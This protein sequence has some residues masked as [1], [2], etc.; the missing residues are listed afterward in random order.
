MSYQEELKGFLKL[1]F[2]EVFNIIDQFEKHV[3][4]NG[5]E[6]FFHRSDSLISDVLIINSIDFNFK[7]GNAN[8]KL[9]V[10]SIDFW[11]LRHLHDATDWKKKSKLK[12][13]MEDLGDKVLNKIYQYKQNL[14][15]VN[16]SEFIASPIKDFNFENAQVTFSSNYFDNWF[17]YFY[18]IHIPTAYNTSL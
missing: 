8:G 1:S 5:E 7:G 13:D 14:Q 17:G 3:C 2:F 18:T 4:E 9:K 10:Y 16:A 11:L 12:I 6:E 15:R